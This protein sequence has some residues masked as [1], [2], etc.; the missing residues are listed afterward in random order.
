MLEAK[1]A[2]QQLRQLPRTYES[3]DRLYA[4]KVDNFDL[5][6][7]VLST[8]NSVFEDPMPDPWLT[9]TSLGTHSPRRLRPMPR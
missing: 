3:F 5:G 4:L 2:M 1:P 9:P 6:A 8:L 7:A